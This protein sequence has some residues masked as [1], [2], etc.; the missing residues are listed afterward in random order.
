MKYNMQ[1]HLRSLHLEFFT[2]V[3][4]VLICGCSTPTQSPEQNVPAAPPVQ[5]VTM[6][7]YEVTE[8][9]SSLAEYYKLDHIKEWYP[10]RILPP[11]FNYNVDLSNK[12]VSEL[13]LL[14]NEIF[15]RNGYLFDDALLR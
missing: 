7:D 2:A 15:A 5:E 3:F 6:T 11:V 10:E 12:T 8:D 1:M 14:R 4:G 13:S 9:K